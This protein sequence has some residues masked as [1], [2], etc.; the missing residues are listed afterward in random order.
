MTPTREFFAERSR[1]LMQLL[2]SVTALGQQAAMAEL[3]ISPGD[4]IVSGNRYGVVF[5]VRHWA[6]DKPEPRVHPV[7]GD[8]HRA[9]PKWREEFFLN[10]APWEIVHPPAGAV[11]HP[12][13]PKSFKHGA[14]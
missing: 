10:G 12:S 8:G 2:G 1:I 9:R 6:A 3:G 11:L 5:G 13:T 4:W 7:Y 14:A